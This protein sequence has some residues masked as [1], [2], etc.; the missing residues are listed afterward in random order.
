MS[1]AKVDKYKKEK[2]N[3]KKAMA[4]EKLKKKIYVIIGAV[5]ALAFVAWIGFSVYNDYIKEDEELSALLESYD[6]EISSES[7][8]ASSDEQSSDAEESSDAENS[9]DADDSSDTEDNE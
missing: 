8:E 1:Q 3:R 6:V 9:S 7:G 4:K 5:V 2:A